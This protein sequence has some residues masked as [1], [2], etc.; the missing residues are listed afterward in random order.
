MT[1]GIGSESAETVFF[2]ISECP[3]AKLITTLLVL[4]SSHHIRLLH[5]ALTESE[6]VSCSGSGVV[7]AARTPC[8][9][10]DPIQGENETLFNMKPSQIGPNLQERLISPLYVARCFVE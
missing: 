8:A 6:L 7:D 3:S 2:G 10:D 9:S 5:N 1:K 4:K